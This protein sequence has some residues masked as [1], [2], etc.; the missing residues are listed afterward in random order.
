MMK[1]EI[2]CYHCKKT[3]YLSG[4]RMEE[5]KTVSCLYCNKRINKSKLKE[6]KEDE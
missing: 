6:A 5:A 3:F 1:E 4:Y 2:F